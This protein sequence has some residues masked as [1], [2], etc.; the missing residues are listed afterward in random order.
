IQSLLEHA[1][2]DWHTPNR[3]RAVISAFTSQPTVLWTPEGLDIYMS[4]IKKMDDANP[5]LASR[6]LQV[7]A[8]WYTLVEPR[9]QMAHE[10]LLELKQT[11]TSK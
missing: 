1:D 9:R 10:Q 4:V 5:V 2:F 6:L 7:L 11:A 8:R 3:V